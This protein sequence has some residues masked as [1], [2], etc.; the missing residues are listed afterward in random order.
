VIFSVRL[1]RTRSHQVLS[2]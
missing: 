1:C 2:F